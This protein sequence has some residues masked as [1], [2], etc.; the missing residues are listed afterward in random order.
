MQILI[1]G[2]TGFIGSALLRTAPSHVRFT[3]LGRSLPD[4]INRP[5]D[6]V[7]SDLSLAGAVVAAKSQLPT[8]VDAVVH[9][10]T[11]R[12][13]R[14]FPDSAS[15]MFETN[16]AAT[17]Y[18]LDYALQA[19]ASRFVL[20]STGT[21]YTGVADGFR[22]DIPLAPQAYFPA[23]KYGAE[24]LATS[25]RPHFAVGILRY[26]VPYGPGQ[27]RDRLVGDLLSRVQEGRPVTLP[28]DG[29]GMVFPTLYID[30]AVRVLQQCL[31][32]GWND[33]VNV[34]SGE[35][36]TVRTA[37]EIIGRVTG[38]L[39]SFE[40]SATAGRL[41]LVPDL[42]RLASKMPVAEFL[43]FGEGVRRLLSATVRAESKA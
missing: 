39:P 1:T 28:E 16:V 38:T 17:A 18:L 27:A 10:A 43:R 29:D 41:R 36:L 13:H 23:T 24:L 14:D 4:G 19:R 15:D 2:A 37:A 21:V 31:E 8:S 3:V 5:V 30:D 6:F 26:F 35:I 9:L 7:P 11:S 32:E 12:R 33:T 42:T 20:G 40:R 25:Y 22:E 34:S